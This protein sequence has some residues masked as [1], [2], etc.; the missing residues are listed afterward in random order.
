MHVKAAANVLICACFLPT[1]AIENPDEES[2]LALLT[3]YAPTVPVDTLRQLCKAFAELRGLVE[4]GT[5]TY[6]YSTR[7]AVA[8]AK[9][10]QRFPRDEVG[11][12]LVSVFAVSIR[13]CGTDTRHCTG[14][15]VCF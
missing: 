12:V 7:E 15:R 11:S 8:V 2:E 6:P 3:A 1:S 4:N 5:I 9:H 13:N 10:L 14:E